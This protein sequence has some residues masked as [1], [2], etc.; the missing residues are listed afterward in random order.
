MAER[1]DVADALARLD[2]CGADGELVALAAGAWRRRP[3]I[4]REMRRR[5]SRPS[6]STMAG[7]Q[8]RLKIAEVAQARAE[9]RAVEERKRR[10]LAI[11]LAVSV[12]LIAALVGGGWSW[13]AHDRAGPRWRTTRTVNEALHCGGAQARPGPVRPG[14]AHLVGRGVRSRESSASALLPACQGNADLRDRVDSLLETV[15]R[16]RNHADLER[17][18]RRTIER[19]AEIHNDLGVHLDGERA[20]AEYAAAFR[21]YGVDIDSLEPDQAGRLLA[22]SPVAIELAN[23]LD[24]WTFIRRSPGDTRPSRRPRLSAVARDGGPRPVAHPAS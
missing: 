9:A 10:L 7:V 19:L 5:S 16:E 23:A 2:G 1:G 18:D 13:V 8:E 12:L 24:Q 4:G 11:G 21:N 14:R 3:R 6:R 22:E 15:T 20:D 17:R